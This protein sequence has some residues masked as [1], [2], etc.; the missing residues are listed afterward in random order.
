MKT[1]LAIIVILAAVTQAI[2]IKYSAKSIDKYVAGG[3]E[4]AKEEG[5][6]P[7][8]LT[9]L[10]DK[11]QLPNYNEIGCLSLCMMKKFNLMDSEL[12]FISEEF[13]QF[14]DNPV[15]KETLSSSMDKCTL[16]YDT[17]KSC[18]IAYDLHKCILVNL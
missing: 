1:T 13:L 9:K 18:Q 15:V 10:N 11:N 12:H 4:C 8:Y 2:E 17:M 16:M 3:K 7:I 6:D 5:V 14:F